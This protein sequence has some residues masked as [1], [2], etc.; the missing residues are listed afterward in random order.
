MAKYVHPFM[1]QSPFLRVLY[2]ILAET[3]RR[4]GNKCFGVYSLF[5]ERTMKFGIIK[6][7]IIDMCYLRIGGLLR[8]TA[9]QSEAIRLIAIQFTTKEV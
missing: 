8:F 2:H 7:N 6:V 4:K 3:G 1:P 5:T 9:K